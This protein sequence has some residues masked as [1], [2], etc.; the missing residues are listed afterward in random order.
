MEAHPPYRLPEGHS[1]SGLP[2]G[3]AGHADTLPKRL[4]PAGLPPHMVPPP[5]GTP[6]PVIARSLRRGNLGR[7]VVRYFG[8]GEC[9]LNGGSDH[10][11][12]RP[13]TWVTV[14]PGT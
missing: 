2:L 6:P 12:V 1:P 4:R 13:G 7:S 11:P 3:S 9:G 10:P 5:L 14:R 8:F